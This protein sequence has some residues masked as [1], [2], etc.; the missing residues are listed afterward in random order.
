M[1]SIY[2]SSYIVMRNVDDPITD[3]VYPIYIGEVQARDLQQARDIAHF[4]YGYNCYIENDE[5][6]ISAT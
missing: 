3:Q 2:G 5:Q 6:T 1:S 4:I